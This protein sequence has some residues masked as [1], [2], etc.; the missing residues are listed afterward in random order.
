[1]AHTNKVR[2]QPQVEPPSP[3]TLFETGS[4]EFEDVCA[5][6]TED[7]LVSASHFATGAL[8]YRCVLLCS[9]M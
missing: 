8:C 7:S 9:F 5:S 1:M 4:L 6:L 3:P 2:G